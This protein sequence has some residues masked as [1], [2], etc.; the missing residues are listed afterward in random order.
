MGGEGEPKALDLRFQRVEH[1]QGATYLRMLAWGVPIT[2]ALAVLVPLF[3]FGG[4]ILVPLMVAVHLLLVRLVLVRQAQRL[5]GPVRRLLNRWTNR[6]AF[7]WIGLPGYGAMM[8]PVVG[9][10]VG[11]GTFVVLTTIAHVSTVV[12]LQRER[13]GHALNG[14]EKAVPVILAVVTVALLLVLIGMAVVFG[15]TVTAI[16]ER[17]QAS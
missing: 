16:A 15:W 6:L 9:I 5:L 1:E 10:A 11:A 13:S 4:I 8:V 12:S 3:H 7:L 2:A 14:W 17:M